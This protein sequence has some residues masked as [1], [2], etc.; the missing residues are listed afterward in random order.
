M[1]VEYG[2]RP[3]VRIRAALNAA[4]ELVPPV[5]IPECNAL[6]FSRTRPRK[7]TGGKQAVRAIFKGI[8]PARVDPLA[9][10]SGAERRPLSIP[11]SDIVGLYRP[12][13]VKPTARVQGS[14]ITNSKRVHP[15]VHSIIER[16]PSP[17]IV[18]RDA[19]CVAVRSL[20]K[21]SADNQIP[22][23]VE[24]NILYAQATRKPVDVPCTCRPLSDKSGR[25]I[26]GEKTATKVEDAVLSESHGR[27]VAAVAHGRSVLQIDARPVL[28][29]P[30]T[31]A[32]VI[33]SFCF[34]LEAPGSG[35]GR[36]RVSW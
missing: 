17:P 30:N 24:Q 28:A 32:D 1:H 12:G 3:A 20:L 2:S 15:T 10:D 18:P 26:L 27:H 25:F 19:R 29:V 13:S 35:K 4:I 33:D 14:V 11:S 6:H 5:A 23:R 36:G 16:V 22:L 8:D 31:P 34:T 7:V 21:P 9:T